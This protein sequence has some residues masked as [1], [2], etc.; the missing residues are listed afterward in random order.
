MIRV[1]NADYVDQ[2]IT[3]RL[4]QIAAGGM[5]LSPA[6]FDVAMACEGMAYVYSSWGAYCTTSERQKRYRMTQIQNIIKACQVLNGSKGSCDGCKWYPDRFRT[7]VWDCRGF[8]EW[9]IEQIT[10]YELYGDTCASQWGH[11]ANWCKK[12]KIGTDPIPQNVLACLYIYKSGKWKHTGLYYNGSTCECS[13]GVQYFEKM[14]ENRWTHWA[15]A[16]P[17][18]NELKEAEDVEEGTAIVIGK[19]LALRKDRS[20]ASKC[21]ARAKTG[22]TVQ[23]VD[24]PPEEWVRVEYK[25]KQGWMMRE[26]LQEGK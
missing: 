22:E 11:E 16:T 20:T 8:T 1:N 26:Y 4:A 9:V 6:C 3:E 18:R 10:G 14:R 23:L 5:L 24:P 15:V 21:L 19:K 12:G 13:S 7:R 17:F 2:L 25:G